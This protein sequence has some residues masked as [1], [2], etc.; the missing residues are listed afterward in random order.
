LAKLDK[1]IGKT[2]LIIAG[3]HGSRYH[4][5]LLWPDPVNV[6]GNGKRRSDSL[7]GS[8]SWDARSHTDSIF[9][10]NITADKSPRRENVVRFTFLRYRSDF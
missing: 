6:I 1:S 8:V 7:R 5:V 4:E 10:R 3:E 9:C 2:A